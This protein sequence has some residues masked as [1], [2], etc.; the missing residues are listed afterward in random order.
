MGPRCLPLCLRKLLGRDGVLE[1]LEGIRRSGK[2]VRGGGTDRCVQMSIAAPPRNSCEEREGEN[3]VTDP[4]VLGWY[5]FPNT[6]F[7]IGH[8]SS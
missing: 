8:T 4:L 2:D 7:V 6:S 1:G 3:S 5:G